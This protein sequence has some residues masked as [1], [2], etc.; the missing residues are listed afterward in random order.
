MRSSAAFSLSIEH[1]VSSA[2]LEAVEERASQRNTHEKKKKKRR[3]EGAREEE[4]VQ[5]GKETLCTAREYYEMTQRKVVHLLPTTAVQFQEYQRLLQEWKAWIAT[6]RRVCS[7]LVSPMASSTTSMR[8]THQMAMPW[9]H[10]AVLETLCLLARPP[11]WWREEEEALEGGDAEEMLV[12]ALRWWQTSSFSSGASFF[13]STSRDFFSF[14]S[15]FIT[16]FVLGSQLRCALSSS[17]LHS[18]KEVSDDD[19]EEEKGSK[20]MKKAF[21]S[22]ERDWDEV[23]TFL[24]HFFLTANEEGEGE[25][26][27]ALPPPWLRFSSCD[28]SSSMD[29]PTAT[30]SHPMGTPVRPSTASAVRVCGT[31]SPGSTPS[32]S[33][34]DSSSHE[35]REEEPW[36]QW[37]ARF[38]THLL[39]LWKSF[40]TRS[41]EPED[42]DHAG[43]RHPFTTSTT[44][45]T[46]IL[47]KCLCFGIARQILEEY[48]YGDAL[49]PPLPLS[50]MPNMNHRK[51]DGQP[52]FGEER[53]VEGGQ[54]RDRGR[55]VIAGRV[56]WVGRALTALPFLF[57]PPEK[58]VTVTREDGQRTSPDSSRY[59]S[60]LLPRRRDDGEEEARDGTRFATTTKAREA[61]CDELGIAI[62]LLEELVD[63]LTHEVPPPTSMFQ[64]LSAPTSATPSPPTTTT[65]T[66]TTG[67]HATTAAAASSS[68]IKDAKQQ[69]KRERSLAMEPRV[70]KKDAATTPHPPSIPTQERGGGAIQEEPVPWKEG[71]TA[72]T[73]PSSSLSSP[74]RSLARRIV[75]GFFSAVHHHHHHHQ[76]P[77]ENTSF[78]ESLPFSFSSSFVL[79]DT[80][81]VHWLWR[82]LLVPL[83]LSFGSDPS[84]LHTPHAL[85]RED[86]ASCG[87]TTAFTTCPSAGVSSCTPNG[88]PP[89]MCMERA[90]RDPASRT[91]C[92][93][94]EG[95]MTSTVT[96]RW[97]PTNRNEKTPAPL[98]YQGHSTSP[99]PFSTEKM[100]RHGNAGEDHAG[101]METQEKMAP[102][103]APLPDWTAN[104]IRSLLVLF[105]R[106]RLRKAT[107][108]SN[109]EGER[110]TQKEEREQHPSYGNCTA[111]TA[112]V[113][114]GATPTAAPAGGLPE[115]VPTD[116][117]RTTTTSA[118]AVD[119][120]AQEEVLMWMAVFFDILFPPP[121]SESFRH[122]IQDSEERATWTAAVGMKDLLWEVLYQTLLYAV[123]GGEDP[124]LAQGPPLG[125]EQDEGLIVE[126]EHHEDGTKGIDKCSL[127]NTRGISQ[128]KPHT[129]IKAEEEGVGRTTAIAGGDAA[130]GMPSSTTP[131]SITLSSSAASSLDAARQMNIQLRVCYVLKR[132]I[133]WEEWAEVQQQQWE[134]SSVDSH[135][136]TFSSSATRT[137]SCSGSGVVAPFV[138]HPSLFPAWDRTRS[139]AAWGSF[140]LILETSNEHHLHI[141]LPAMKRLDKLLLQHFPS[142]TCHRD[143]N[144]ERYP[145]PA[146]ISGPK[147][148][149][150]KKKHKGKNEAEDEEVHQE[151]EWNVVDGSV[152]PLAAPWIEL[153][154]VKLLKHPNTA[155]RKVTLRRLWQEWPLLF[156]S[157]SSLPTESSSRP[158]CHYTQLFSLRFLF[159]DILFACSDPRLCGDMDRLP[160]STRTFLEMRA[161]EWEEVSDIETASTVGEP[162][163]A[164]VEQFFMHLFRE[165]ALTGKER[166]AALWWILRTVHAQQSRFTLSMFARVFAGVA[167]TLY[168]EAVEWEKKKKDEG[169]GPTAAASIPNPTPNALRLEKVNTIETPSQA[170]G[171]RSVHRRWNDVDELEEGPSATLSM[172]LDMPNIALLMGLFREHI[173][174]HVPFWLEVRLSAIFFS[175]FMHFM[176]IYPEAFHY[177]CDDV[178]P[179]SSFF[180]S[181]SSSELRP[182]RSRSTWRTA[183]RAFWRLVSHC[184]PL[185]LSG[186]HTCSKFDSGG[187]LMISGGSSSSAAAGASGSGLDPS[188]LA[189]ALVTLAARSAPA[190]SPFSSVDSS[191]STVAASSAPLFASLPF[192]TRLL[193]LST[194]MNRTEALLRGTLW[195][196]P[197]SLVP[198]SLSSLHADGTVRC[199]NSLYGLSLAMKEHFF[200]IRALGSCPFSTPGSPRTPGVPVHLEELKAITHMIVHSAYEGLHRPYAAPQHVVSSLMA[201]VEFHR[202][203]GE[204]ED[205]EDEDGV[206]RQEK[207]ACH[208]TGEA[209]GDSLPSPLHLDPSL[210]APFLPMTTGV[211]MHAGGA[212]GGW[213]REE[214]SW[215][216]SSSSLLVALFHP[217]VSL[218]RDIMEILEAE[219]VDMLE[220]GCA[221][222][223]DLCASHDT[224]LSPTSLRC[225]G[226]TGLQSITHTARMAGRSGGKGAAMGRT[227]LRLSPTYWGI[228]TGAIATV[229][230]VLGIL[231]RRQDDPFHAKREDGRTREERG[232]DA[233][234]LWRKSTT[235]TTPLSSAVPFS[236]SVAGHNT[237]APTARGTSMARWMESL[238]PMVPTLFSYLEKLTANEEVTHLNEVEGKKRHINSTT[239]CPSTTTTVGGDSIREA[240]RWRTLLVH[241]ALTA[242]Q[243][244]LTGAVTTSLLPASTTRKKAKKEKES[245]EEGSATPLLACSMAPHHE[246]EMSSTTTTTT[247]PIPVVFTVVPRIQQYMELLLRCLSPQVQPR[248]GTRERGKE[249][250]G[251][252][253][254]GEMETEEEEEGGVDIFSSSFSL[255]SSVGAGIGQGMATPTADTA[256]ARFLASS[257]LELDRISG[258]LWTDL[259]MELDRAAHNVLFFF[260]SYLW[261]PEEMKVGHGPHV[262]LS[263]HL[264]PSCSCATSVKI[265]TTPA[266]ATFLETFETF[267]LN[268]LD[269]CWTINLPCVYDLLLWLC[270]LPFCNADTTPTEETESEE[271]SSEDTPGDLPREPLI[272]SSSLPSSSKDPSSSLVIPVLHRGAMLEAMWLHRHDVGAKQQTRLSAMVYGGAIRLC[273]PYDPQRV[274]TLLKEELPSLG[275]GDDEW[276]AV[277]MTSRVPYLAAA[278]PSPSPPSTMTPEEKRAQKMKK[279]TAGARK[280]SKKNTKL[281]TSPRDAYY[282]ASTVALALLEQGGALGTSSPTLP[283]AKKPWWWWM[284]TLRPLLLYWAVLYSPARDPENEFTQAVTEVVMARHWPTA[285]R[286]QYPASVNISL[287]G[288]TLCIST[289]LWYVVQHPRLPSSASFSPGMPT[290]EELT[291]TLLHWST[292]HPLAISEPCM[293]NSETHRIRIRV[294][295]LLCALQPCLL[296]PSSSHEV[297]SQTMRIQSA[298]H[299]LEEV[300]GISLYRMNLGSVRKLMELYTIRV[301]QAYPSLYWV[302]E[303][304]LSQYNQLRPQ[305]MGTFLLITG[306]ILLSHEEQW[307]ERFCQRIAKLKERRDL[308]TS[309]SPYRSYTRIAKQEDDE[310]SS[311]SDEIFE[312]LFPRLLQQCSSHQHLLRIISSVV[313]HRVGKARLARW[314]GQEAAAEQEAQGISLTLGR[315]DGHGNGVSRAKGETFSTASGLTCRTTEQITTK[316]ASA[317]TTTASD[318]FPRGVKELL[319]YIETAEEHIKFREKHEN[320]LFY[321]TAQ[322][323]S[324]RSIFCLQRGE[325]DMILC[326]ALPASFFE[327]MKDIEQEWRCLLGG[328]TRFAFNRLRL[329]RLLV[330]GEDFAQGKE[331][332]ATQTLWKALQ[333]SSPSTLLHRTFAHF[334]L[335][336]HTPHCTNC[337]AD[338]T[339]EAMKALWQDPLGE[340]M[341]S[342]NGAVTIPKKATGTEGGEREMEEEDENLQRKTLSWWTSEVHDELHP[343]CLP[344]HRMGMEGGHRKGEEDAGA[345]PYSTKTS[346]PHSMVVVASL[347]EN[348]VNIAGLCRCADIFAVEQLV[349]PD[350]TVFDH[351]HFVAVARSAERWVPW[352]A[353]PPAQLPA[354]FAEMREKGYTIVGI[355]QTARSVLISEY[356]FPLKS[357]MVLGAEGQG[358][359]ASLI[360]LLDVC[361]EI[362]QYGLVRSLNVH[363]TGALSMY[364]YVL[365]HICKGKRV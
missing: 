266:A 272:S 240:Q 32:V 16:T 289:L 122:L 72:M 262:S 216:S 148:R 254:E 145:T 69:D 178:P 191:S 304:H 26:E 302:L 103:E 295:Q 342:M 263:E 73:V 248:Q 83:L 201:L 124:S 269:T 169:R 62:L 134:S 187:Q 11:W 127:V 82:Q 68:S 81:S 278:T 67:S 233:V 55:G 173:Q 281:I 357:V 36:L 23:L 298:Q 285:V 349:V 5:A 133:H 181:S 18:E 17:S 186:G 7:P 206:A 346:H 355:E 238:S 335:I 336:P 282:A 22:L 56:D 225:F 265:Y 360:P 344:R 341:K 104:H 167:V 76:Q 350:V 249:P 337:C 268:Q 176:L 95:S 200:L 65:K 207:D 296:H 311:P 156:S 12:S 287:L 252:G 3:D 147:K 276:E 61:S 29:R 14:L 215:S 210:L 313:L 203:L 197:S 354:Y 234:E 6:V 31:P 326:D 250:Q 288:R 111:A 182:H 24:T 60:S 235:T 237:F 213:K 297:I 43:S 130:P 63:Q 327:R 338:F 138:S 137:P 273:L 119:W 328:G 307:K 345:G 162:I 163:T 190:V 40:S 315:R 51:H 149:A 255:A 100:E 117:H 292:T 332:R 151:E 46:G 170:S 112:N 109:V 58:S 314:E 128:S 339:V 166:R 194:L 179:V 236:S 334:P 221:H 107:A 94:E 79:S 364:E 284:K 239:S 21:F 232:V 13:T 293:P 310:A 259:L 205:T 142:A 343:A 64:H 165:R 192:M 246:E 280:Q 118:S 317:T 45:R 362:P 87:R 150:Q 286:L 113:E 306:H 53:V 195:R 329:R 48:Q 274:M 86:V 93:T 257:F 105:L 320:V 131:P 325:A 84:F 160:I 219:V 209:N 57:T 99:F 50:W 352:N 152:A 146:E 49:D 175:A 106:S 319:A 291:R 140:F 44:K 115:R 101:S 59:P 47:G 365:Q 155:V 139:A 217:H 303:Q 90:K 15:R 358:I 172:V 330:G 20:E 102:I 141:M 52:T 78:A 267:L 301:L 98:R 66:T 208:G 290:A 212:P 231:E 157:S 180:H 196:A 321:D 1:V 242:L 116:L 359:P 204:T 74:Y 223:E 34:V 226:A 136:G 28:G 2:F 114:K 92:I 108:T 71:T 253:E 264:S 41:V 174:D 305:V 251:S 183:R 123:R 10:S 185:G 158:S 241:R 30:T 8:P 316:A 159:S 35:G 97:Q 161:F 331:D 211:T 348:P 198:S 218:L 110:R 228:L 224:S 9:K 260:C 230:T 75:I 309:G 54:E 121:D 361:V 318:C 308:L 77:R 120:A 351:P 144:K 154:L 261:V 132:L 4:R 324:P 277:P 271:A 91:A 42:D 38:I 19:E 126:E 33:V 243:S 258:T 184:G 347:L 80:P 125:V 171:P 229:G 363:V 340:K 312:V 70:T 193:G 353:V 247:T 322:M 88:T 279:N 214:V 300:A 299:V 189:R 177:W 356:S 294:W 96:S 333:R 153:L 143:G 202:S 245:R 244:T 129:A 199:V 164:S 25:E 135:T 323:S 37:R 283:F 89:A 222:W 256:S 188:F 85:P 227:A 220:I 39:Q 270:G 275:M 168:E 27:E